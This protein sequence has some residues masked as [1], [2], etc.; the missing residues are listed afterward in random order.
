VQQLQSF[1]F[2]LYVNGS[3][4][5][6]I[7]IRCAGTPGAAGHTCSG[8][9]PPM[10]QGRQTLELTSLLGG[11]ESARS[12]PIN[13]NVTAGAAQSSSA[14]STSPSIT[15]SASATSPA[16]QFGGD[17][18]PEGA[19]LRPGATAACFAGTTPAC[20][21]ATEVATGLGKVS[22]LVA[23]PDGR[24]LFVEDD[25]RVRVMANDMLLSDAALVLD[26]RA[27]RIVGLAVDHDFANSGSVFVA[28]TD[29]DPG[30]ASVLNIT[31]YREL[32][33]T[34]GQGATIVTGLPFPAGVNAPLAVDAAGLLYV[35]LPAA[36][37]EPLASAGLVLRYTRDGL[38]PRDSAQASPI[39]GYGFSRP[40]SLAFDG[41]GTIWLTGEKA[42]WGGGLAMLP[43]AG[44][45][46]G[47]WPLQPQAVVAGGARG[48]S[49]EPRVLLA[50][51]GRLYEIG[52][53]TADTSGRIEEI[54]LRPRLPILAGL[55]DPTGQS[56]AAVATSATESAVLRLR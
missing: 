34:L 1:T 10:G 39:F 26:A 27:T 53:W 24:L 29:V 44:P 52:L 36:G 9:L 19:G 2:R 14:A 16:G 37:T 3:A 40:S 28:W 23:T 15:P 12:A 4:A 22:N 48:D 50:N 17:G 54:T 30:G 45:R 31:R 56:Y 42:G 7:D 38:T 47:P 32:Q 33:N 20:S 51:E 55:T 18:Q 46:P 11:V 43:T 49:T 35:A 21:E 8:G 41:Q 6:L 25:S 13:V 5:S